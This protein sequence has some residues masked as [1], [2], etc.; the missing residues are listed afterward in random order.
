MLFSEVIKLSDIGPVA[1]GTARKVFPL[2]GHSELLVKIISPQKPAN[3]NPSSGLKKRLKKLLKQGIRKFIYSFHPSFKHRYTIRE[4]NCELRATLNLGPS[5]AQSPLARS[6]GVVQTDLGPGVVVERISGKDGELA[7][8]LRD[9]IKAGSLTQEIID[10][11]NV[12]VRKLYDLQVVAHDIHAG[13]IVYGYRDGKN[14]FF[15]VDGYGEYN[16]IPVR[17]FLRKSNDYGLDKCFVIAARKGGLT[18]D[19]KKREFKYDGQS[20][21][22]FD[23]PN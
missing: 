2:P 1:K 23:N 18:W 6:L 19:Q 20:T 3:R 13:N 17:S 15:L 5:I 9:I 7:V 8:T 4:I 11:L 14:V 16:V 21:R 12:L 22:Y 10:D